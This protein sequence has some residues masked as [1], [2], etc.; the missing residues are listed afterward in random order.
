MQ[1]TDH[2]RTTP[3]SLAVPPLHLF[4]PS[5]PRSDL[6][7]VTFAPRL[8]CLLIV[9]I[10]VP[11]A[12]QFQGAFC[13]TA[14]ACGWVWA[15]YRRLKEV[16]RQQTAKLQCMTQ[17]LAARHRASTT[18]FDANCLSRQASCAHDT[19]VA[20]FICSY[21][22]QYA[23]MLSLQPCCNKHVQH[24]G[25]RGNGRYA[26]RYVQ[27][28]SKSKHAP[29]IVAIGTLATFMLMGEANQMHGVLK[30]ADEPSCMAMLV[31]GPIP[32]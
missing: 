11:L 23:H 16:R 28:I 20:Y 29:M 25:H 2:C 31:V 9:Y 8:V 4:S 18:L 14:L 12:M 32:A 17:N 13:C 22:F 7:D 19:K 5:E 1:H 27:V 24:L 6:T 30:Q 10:D 3:E 15:G 26:E 21:A